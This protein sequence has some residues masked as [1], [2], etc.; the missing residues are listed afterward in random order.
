MPSPLSSLLFSFLVT[1]QGLVLTF[2]C[3]PVRLKRKMLPKHRQVPI[4]LANQPFP[5]QALDRSIGDC[6]E[7]QVGK[8]PSRVAIASKN[9]Q[10]TYQIL[11]SRANATA[12][13][14]LDICG[15]GLERIALLL[16]HDAPAIT[17]ILAVLK[18]GKTYIPLDPTYPSSRL[19][20]ILEDS[21]VE[22]ILTNNKNWDLAQNIGQGKIALIN[23]DRIESSTAV[24]NLALSISPETPAYILYTSGSTGIPKG[25]VQTHRNILHSIATYTN[26][27]RIS[28]EDQLTLLSSY[29]FEAAVK[30][31]FTALLN[32]ATLYPFDL[33]RESLA[34]L[35]EWLREQEITIYHSTPTVYR[36]FIETLSGNSLSSGTQFPKIRLVV[37]GGEGC[38]RTD[39]ESY[40]K[41][42]GQNCFFVN[43]LG[44]TESA[45]NRLYL[46]DCQTT[47]EENTVP[48]GYK[49][50]D[51]T[52][53]LLL[54]EAGNPTESYGEIAIRS[55]YLALGYWQKPE[56]TQAAFLPD[57]EGGN[58]RIY[59]TG[60]LGRLR[61]DGMLELLGRQDFQV[62]I[63]GFRVELGE[64]ETVLGQ[65]HKV[66]ETAVIHR[67]DSPG[68]ERLVAYI[69]AAADGVPDIAELQGF[70]FQKLP[71]Y[72]VPSAFMMLEALPLT[73]NGKVDRR[74]LPIPTGDRSNL[75]AVYVEPQSESEGIL[76]AIWQE[77]LR[78]SQVGRNDN[79]LE[80]GGHSLL[81]TQIVSSI[82]TAFQI[83][84]SVA[85]L[86][87]EL[88]VASLAL[89]IDRALQ[90]EKAKVPPTPQLAPIARPAN[91][92]LSYFQEQLWFLTQL[93]PDSIAYNQQVTI[94][95]HSELD[96]AALQQSLNEIV[97]RHEALRTRFSVAKGES[98]LA[99]ASEVSLPVREFD[100]RGLPEEERDRSARRLGIKQGQQ[101]FDLSLDLPLRGTLVQLGNKDYK[102][103]LSIHHINYDAFSLSI[104]V[105]ELATLYQAF[106]DGKPSPL[107]ELTVQYADFAIWQRE[108]MQGIRLTRGLDYWKEQLRDTV[109]ILQLPCDRPRPAR[110]SFRGARERVALSQ[111]LSEAI[112]TLSRQEGATLYMTLLAAFLTLLYRYCNQEDIVVGT[113]AAIR[114]R[115]EIES[116]IGYFVNMLMLRTDVSGNPSFR[117]LLA[118]VRSVN[119]EA[120][121][122]QHIPFSKLVEVLDV[123]RNL[124]H[125]PLFQVAFDLNQPLPS[126]DLDWTIR[127]E[128]PG[129][130][131][132]K[133]DLL[134]VLQNSP[135]GLV[136]HFE[137]NTDLFEAD[138]IRRMVA[139]YQTLL[140][141]IVANPDEHLSDLPLLTA[142]ERHQLLVE[143]NN[144]RADYPQNKCIH[145]LFEEQVER[146][147]DAVAVV[148]EEDCPSLLAADREKTRT[149][150]TYQ[151]L[152]DRANQLA[153]Y[154]CSLGVGPEVR[155]GIYLDRSIHAIIAVMGVIKAGGAYIP[156][157][158][159]WPI[160][161]VELILSSQAVDYLVTQQKYWE[162]V[163]ELRSQ[164]PP[165][166]HAICLDVDAPL[167]QMSSQ[168]L[169][170]VASSDNTAYIIYTSGS[171]GIPKGV[172]VRH[173]AA[174]NLIDWVNKTFQVGA[175]DRIL[176]VT[177]LCFDL[178]VYDIFGLL[179]AGGS[180]QVASS[181]QL[182]HPQELLR[183][184]KRE[185]I[186]FW[187]SAPASLQQL[188]P[189]F[190]S[191]PPTHSNLRLVFLSGDW[192]PTALPERVKAAFPRVRVVSLGGATEATIWSNYYPIETVEPAWTSI[193]YGK[194]IQNA[195]YYILDSYL[196]PCPIGVSGVLHIGGDCLAA[197]Y[198]DPVK[199]SQKF[200]RDPFSDNPSSRLYNTGDKARYLR[201]GNIEFLGRID[202]QVKIRGF[203]IE[204]GEIEVTL[205]QHPEVREAVVAIREDISGDKQLVAYLVQ[206]DSQ[207]TINQIRSFL[208]TKLPYY[209]VPSVFVFL[210]AIPLTSN[211]KIDRRA[212][213]APLSSSTLKIAPRTLA[214]ELIAP[215]WAEVL[216]LEKVGI[217]DNFFEIGGNSLK[218]MQA[219]ARIGDTFSVELPV[220]ELFQLPT[221]AEL[222][223]WIE[224]ARNKTAT[225]SQ[226]PAI[227]PTEKDADIP[228]SFAQ[229]R[230][231]FL[232]QLEGKSPT[233]NIHR[234]I[235]LD[236][237]LDISALEA[238]LGEIVCRH[239]IL[240]TTF[241]AKN[242][243]PLQIIAPT[244]N[245][246]LPVIDLQHLPEA[247]R[248]SEVQRLAL[249]EA[250]EPFDIATES[251]IRF[252]L[253]RLSA[254]SSVLLLTIHHIV[255]DGWS[256]GVFFRELQVLYKAFSQNKPSPLPELPV[257]Y[258]DF[259]IWQRQYL[260][261]EVLKANLNYWEQNLAGIPPL[262]ELPTDRPR[263]RVQ[264]FRGATAS[265][266]LSVELTQKLLAV[267]QKH[268]TT[269]FMT[270]LAAF[271][272]LL[273]RYSGQ[274]DIV[275]G[276]PI[277][278]RDRPEIES[279]IGFFVNTLVLRMNFAENP[280]FVS[281]LH[282]VR[283]I[284][285]DAYSH[286][287]L[288][289][290]QLV[291]EL[292]PE[293]NNHTP[294]FQ[295]MF[296]LQNTVDE[297][298]G[299]GWELPGLKVSR[300]ETR[301]AT[302]KF[303]LTLSMEETEA[304]LIGYWEY[305]TDL[306]D[307]ATIER[308]S[309][310]FQTL[311]GAI[312][313]NPET[314]AGELPLLTPEERDRLL[315][316]WN[317]T[318]A[319]YP[320]G[321]CIHQLFEEQVE[322]TPDA[323]A[324]V[325][326]EE[327]L[328][329]RELNGKAN[330]LAHYLQGLGVGPEVLVG[331]CVERSLSMIVGLLG[332]LK[333]GGAYVPLDPNYPS[334]R[335]AYMLEDSSVQV[336]LIQQGLRERLHQQEVRV[337]CLDSD[338][339]GLLAPQSESNPIAIASSADNLAYINYTSGSTGKPKGVE[340]THRGVTSLLFGTDYINFSESEKFLHLAPIAFDAS[341]FEIWGA[342]LHGAPCVLFPEKVPTS[343]TLG[344]A[345]RQHDIT[346]LFLTTALFNSIVDDE[347][348]GLSGVRQLLM[349]GEVI[350]VAHVRKALKALSSTQ[351]THVYGPTEATTFACYY[352]I[353]RVIDKSIQSIPI[354]RPIVNTQI[355]ILDNHLQPVP[356]GVPGELHIGGAGLAR[357]YLN[358]PELTSQKF[359]PNPF[360]DEPGSR[361]YKTGDKARYLPDGNIEFIGRIDN[362]VKIRGF[363]IE[364][365]EIEATLAQHPEV[366][367][368]VVIVREDNPGDKRLVA[369]I[370]PE[371]Q[372]ELAVSVFRSFLKSKLPDYM[373]PG[374][375]VFLEAIPLTPNGK[376]D[377]HALAVL[378][379]STQE[380]ERIAPRTT[381][382]LQLVQI[383][384][385]VLNLP[386]VGVRDDFFDLGG[387]S[388]LATC[389]M[390]R[391]EEQ[392][393]VKLS[394][395]ALFSEPTIE[396][397]ASLF[398]AAPNTQFFSP[399]VPIQ[400]KGSLPPF[401]CVHPVGGNVLCYAALARQ[402]DAE[403]PFYAL[404]ALGLNGENQPLTNIEDMA[405]TYIQEIQTVRPREAYRLGG[406]SFGGIVAFEMARQLQAL[407]AE[408]EI[409][410]LIDSFNPT[411]LNKTKQD[412]AMQAVSFAKHL[413]RSFD[414]E[415]SVSEEKL[416]QLELDEQLNYILEVAKILKILPSE[417]GLE[418]IQQ[419]FA[420]FQANIQAMHGYVPQPY[421][422]SLTLFCAEEKLAGLASEQIHGWSSLAAGGINIHK[423]AGDH[424]SIIRSEALAKELGFYLRC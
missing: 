25:V 349:G 158:P 171:T 144:T 314:Q 83:E 240:R 187:D 199:T 73:P 148:Y 285:L 35:A 48:V 388:L 183:L 290:E 324:V 317:D 170:P 12:N 245:R 50:D 189:F 34:S 367:E 202:N 106:V 136:G 214:E 295:V 17:C 180:I 53:I 107:P 23:I 231:W 361:L 342:L 131:T 204:L 280:S 161:R 264:R 257:Q 230:L 300:L 24:P 219:I 357:G 355:Y 301:N 173:K 93:H 78:V 243:T 339:V 292:Q 85:D 387:H 364:L 272:I 365:G 393:G 63:R 383:W 238:A 154:L 402:F 109:P 60:D 259:A 413:S 267:S 424:F 399:L 139:H 341:T 188:V 293:R 226:L 417:M 326:E 103:F 55:P 86:F 277:A 137:Y 223:Q 74:N 305:N 162:T 279:L 308:T 164:Q 209:M 378:D 382:E 97:H 414:K 84:L 36:H 409:L 247:I 9:H 260:T 14:V 102:L 1:P 174:V 205:T 119:L 90:E 331:I 210:E 232:D 224:T 129:I 318:F 253:L 400:P 422:G 332:I 156:L 179:A 215:I 127:M 213:P 344:N 420:V 149:I 362:Q 194:P 125:N 227:A 118:R 418:Q 134:I 46:I 312:A 72:M 10:W 4:V 321:K 298:I 143:W 307:A 415:L 225:V 3:P 5:L 178:S 28:A 200:I 195:R 281:L 38:V 408:V 389:L 89:R 160:A 21:Q 284:C 57:P 348:E 363:R 196:N 193:P 99:I 360:S 87:E 359:I 412:E 169:E 122:H 346:T 203:R 6:F 65:Y 336:L 396:S 155:V 358:R 289:F 322:R 95:I 142:D 354:G 323:V 184:L 391:I 251:L 351:I 234:T 315:V 70:L 297:R 88:T 376:S 81:A 182:Q 132:A 303:D 242:G 366:R 235:R 15:T 228:L 379:V 112:A 135:S 181:E 299:E 141:G 7:A 330:Q 220:R 373:V 404:Q 274:E 116:V 329:Y 45:L 218:A 92:P 217:N 255:A 394:V 350:S 167:G 269:L 159:Q 343:K 177:S 27:L 18:L 320:Q 39:V 282:R 198:D 166:T 390:A 216:G 175:G 133:F 278:N 380:A 268:G 146:M 423:I 104:L 262:L 237:S 337:V 311:L 123:D 302:A 94:D 151:E 59:R 54:D 44:C 150:L 71:D 340:V 165:I 328:T 411:V 128:E 115:P 286:R 126:L 356:I 140:A 395:A 229:Q 333:A 29:S 8:A 190:P 385:E 353:R 22:V 191:T 153:R 77:V 401:F 288:P 76:A 58:Q 258:A 397:Q 105:R 313:A 310:H 381:T 69:V 241:K 316:E 110:Q 2:L 236:G 386:V 261:S 91:L 40:K 41:Y 416:Q 100:L 67:E 248:E 335:L 403:Q 221:I 20:Y 419:L 197:G 185:P 384:S 206:H 80:L 265:F 192:I 325:F 62:K 319:P 16:E 208:K 163:R 306:F 263:P 66:L 26:Q 51:E 266:A 98:V 120:Y 283:E 369:Y 13:Y 111:Q 407:G 246:D 374:P 186:T 421:S 11:N 345:I 32:G 152:N 244:F 327:R 275:V 108:W 145:Q 352:P 168:N 96:V 296:V 75:G 233:Y 252:S 19:T 157:D 276:S 52:E 201:D 37:L 43:L 347:P 239:E 406:W 271:S 398:C 42:F 172:I 121:A 64:I 368:A 82:Q 222:A 372:Q 113:A 410:A 370:V 405:A 138:T 101:C 130:N 33:K 294:L 147:P 256:L 31:I 270:L 49:V 79:F 291:E 68:R 61:P 375:F 338:W 250:R 309:G 392:L 304:G 211:G 124:S 371:G 56:L 176:F 249:E 287:D 47:I 254:E 334:D 114:N 207:P 117:E 212:L 377:R 30:D 273:Y